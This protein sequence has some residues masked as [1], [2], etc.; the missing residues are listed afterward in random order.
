[1]IDGPVSRSR[2]LVQSLAECPGNSKALAV[3]ALAMI[4]ARNELCSQEIVLSG[5]IAF[6]VSSRKR[7]PA[8]TLGYRPPPIEWTFSTQF[9]LTD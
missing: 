5:F 1:M 9:A 4:K 6:T 7:H 8:S 3:G 2:N